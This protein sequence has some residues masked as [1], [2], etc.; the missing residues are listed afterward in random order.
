MGQLVT[1]HHLPRFGCLLDAVD[2]GTGLHVLEQIA[3][4][5]GAQR[6]D[7][8]LGGVGHGEDDDLA[9][10]VA[11]LDGLERLDPVHPLHIEVEEHDVGRKTA[12]QL[13]AFDA[14]RRLADHREFAPG[15]PE[16]LLQTFAE[17]RMVVDDQDLIRRSWRHGST[18]PGWAPRAQERS[19]PR[20]GCRAACAAQRQ[21]APGASARR[22]P[23]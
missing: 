4:G 3:V 14:G 16:Q 9:G 22:V 7:Q 10:Q 12:G 23:A 20:R 2:Q 1:Q 11:R 5:A 8:V 18:F 17:Q 21:A 6:G 13:D 19:T 15:Q